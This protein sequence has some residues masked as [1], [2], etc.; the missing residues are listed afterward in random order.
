MNAFRAVMRPVNKIETQFPLYEPNIINRLIL[1]NQNMSAFNQSAGLRDRHTQ[2][3]VDGRALND[4]SKVSEGTLN[5]T[6]MPQIL[7]YA[8][9]QVGSLGGT[10][11]YKKS[12]TLFEC[13]EMFHQ[14]MGGPNPD[15]ANKAYSMKP[16]GG[17]IF[18]HMPNGQTYPILITEDKV[19]GTNDQRLAEGLARQAL[20]NAIERAAKNV[21][22]SEMLFAGMSVFPYL[23]FA[24]GCDF[25]PSETIAKRIEMMNL[26]IPN[27]TIALNP[28]TTE[29]DITEKVDAILPNINIE[30]R[31]G[32]K[33]F[34]AFIK[35]HKWN[36]MAHGSSRWTQAEIVKICC[37]VIDLV[38]PTIREPTV[39]L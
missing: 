39:L 11:S 6:A 21:R 9:Q 2:L 20:G 26:G 14:K 12:I 36:E 8:R 17:I 3:H 30:N 35:T 29:T 24:S 31:F 37:H 16:D 5:I 38:L 32:S 4:D 19:Q 22:G 25:D 18:A 27:H 13:Q 15:P 10:I 23:V 7:E 33:I 28:N 34:S 1:D